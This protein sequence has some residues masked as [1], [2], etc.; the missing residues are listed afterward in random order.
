MNKT[1]LKPCPFCGGKA[2]IGTKTFDVFNMAAYV[3]C[4][5]CNAR[6]GLIKEDVNYAAIEKAKETWNHRVDD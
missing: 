6:T 3:F 5:K 1:E 2:S 4:T